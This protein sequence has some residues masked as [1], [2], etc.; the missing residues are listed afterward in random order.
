MFVAGLGEV[1]GGSLSKGHRDAG[2]NVGSPLSET[3]RQ[4][5]IV[6]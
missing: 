4:I 3:R 5:A 6:V 2:A 1:E